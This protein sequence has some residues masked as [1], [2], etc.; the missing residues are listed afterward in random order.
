MA[1]HYTIQ[2]SGDALEIR[3]RNEI[4]LFLRVACGGF[5]GW[6]VWFVI[7]T[8]LPSPM[9]S[10]LAIAGG[11]C[12]FA[13]F[14]QM[15]AR[16]TVTGLEFQIGSSSLPTAKIYRLEFQE[17]ESGGQGLYAV[18]ATGE[19]VVLPHVDAAQANE[20][21]AAVKKKFPGLAEMWR[22]SEAAANRPAVGAKR[23]V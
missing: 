21:I 3:V 23:F 8:H 11:V 19:P 2:E 13:L 12:V 17:H 15:T 7:G 1:V 22:N 10:G 20:I 9:R 16:V 6:L 14:R 18:T 5:A 4:S